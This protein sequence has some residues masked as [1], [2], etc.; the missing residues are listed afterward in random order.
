M[1]SIT[2]AVIRDAWLADH[3]PAI[4]AAAVSRGMVALTCDE[5]DDDTADNHILTVFMGGAVKPG[6]VSAST[7]NQ[8]T[9]LSTI[10]MAPGL[11]TF[12][13]AR[14]QAPVS[15]VW[16]AAAPSLVVCPIRSNV[17]A[18]TQGTDGRPVGHS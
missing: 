5:D 6:A 2:N 16:A 14:T 18:A 7:I 15:D 9:V 8:Y 17:K 10:C 12:G 13:L 1:G 11:P 4:I 3:V